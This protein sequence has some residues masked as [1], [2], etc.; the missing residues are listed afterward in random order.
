RLGNDVYN[1]VLFSDRKAWATFVLANWKEVTETNIWQYGGSLV[2]RAACD[3]RRHHVVLR[4]EARTAEAVEATFDTLCRNL[5]LV[6]SPRGD[7]YRYRRSSLEFEIGNWRPDCFVIG[8]E[9]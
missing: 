9:R 8:I 6:V 2:R 5:S 1:R 4:V 3:H 7:P